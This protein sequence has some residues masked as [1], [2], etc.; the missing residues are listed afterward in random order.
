MTKVWRERQRDGQSVGRRE[1]REKCELKI[2]FDKISL[3]AV[4]QFGSFWLLTATCSDTCPLMIHA[5]SP[6]AG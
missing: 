5:M 1:G 4:E 3:D 2:R 6:V